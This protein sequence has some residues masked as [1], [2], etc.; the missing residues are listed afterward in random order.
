MI[1]DEVAVRLNVYGNEASIWQHIANDFG[2]R[3]CVDNV[4]ND[5]PTLTG[6]LEGLE[7]VRQVLALFVVADDPDRLDTMDSE[8]NCKDLSRHHTAA[9]DGSNSVPRAPISK[10]TSEGDRRPMDVLPSDR[11]RF[12]ERA[13][14]VH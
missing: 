13:R 4:V 7:Y 9:G 2:G 8:L 3:A 12:P 11:P 5:E 6:T 1:D 14:L 10:L